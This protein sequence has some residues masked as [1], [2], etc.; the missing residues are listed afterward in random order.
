M[1]LWAAELQKVVGYPDPLLY[2][3]LVYFTNDSEVRENLARA[4]KLQKTGLLESGR[5]LIL[6]LTERDGKTPLN[7]STR[8]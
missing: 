2:N 6:P 7:L 8:I 1:T 3:K 5:L 4:D